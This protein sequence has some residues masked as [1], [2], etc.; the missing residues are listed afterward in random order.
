MACRP[1]SLIHLRSPPK[2]NG[3]NCFAFDRFGNMFASKE[4][5]LFNDP[6]NVVLKFTPDGVGSTFASGLAHY[7]RGLAFDRNNNLFVA[8]AG[9][10]P[11]PPPASD[12]GDI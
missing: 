1:F 3:P 7:P 10:N 2:N 4:S 9:V 5:G 11:I 8:E 12:P 6:T